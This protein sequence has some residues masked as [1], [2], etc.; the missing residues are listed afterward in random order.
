MAEII[1]INIPLSP[2]GEKLLTIPEKINVPLFS[3]VQW[4]IIGLDKYYFQ[5]DL[6][7]RGLIFT[8]YF[9]KET[10]FR[11]KRQ[12]VQIHEDPRFFPHYPNRVLRL[13]EDVADEKGSF[14]YG[15]RVSEAEQNETL[16]DEDP[17]L[18]VY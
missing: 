15:I 14:K 17:I 10:P 4:N 16:Y 8:L 3:V 6:R 7:R 2:Q 1:R 9:D 12:F 11:W 18:I 5:T 13:A